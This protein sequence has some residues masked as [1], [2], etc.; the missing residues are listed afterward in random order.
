M[1]LFIFFILHPNVEIKETKSLLYF[2]VSFQVVISTIIYPS[3]FAPFSY[4]N[5]RHAFFTIIKEEGGLFSGCLFRGL[6]PSLI[7]SRCVF[8]YNECFYL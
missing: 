3:Y 6:G 7:V 1:I 5:I 8:V 2:A 4:R